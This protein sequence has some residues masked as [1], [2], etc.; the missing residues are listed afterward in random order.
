MPSGNN[1]PLTSHHFYLPNGIN[2]K[3]DKKT[4]LTS[5]QTGVWLD[6]PPSPLPFQNLLHPRQG[7]CA[8]FLG[9]VVLL[10]FC[11][12]RSDISQVLYPCTSPDNLL[13]IKKKKIEKVKYS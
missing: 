13:T 5:R 12:S 2:T 1:A 4:R 3:L 11:I 6:L 7:S 8:A 10:L 9:S